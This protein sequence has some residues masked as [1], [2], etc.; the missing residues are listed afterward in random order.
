MNRSSD[1]SIG[2]PGRLEWTAFILLLLAEFLVFDQVGAAPFTRIYPRWN[3]QIQY[4]AESYTGY[5][6]LKTKGVLSAF[7]SSLATPT[8][9]GTLHDFYALVVFS[10]AGPSR[11]AALAVNMLALLVWQAACFITVRRIWGSRSLAWASCGILISL[12]APWMDIPGS[13]FD[14]RLDWMTACTMGTTLCACILARGFRNLG[15]SLVFGI[16]AALTLLTR[17]L[18]G[19]YFVLIGIGLLIWILTSKDRAV[20][21]RNL[22]FASL[23]ASLVA[24]PLMWLSR[25]EL[26]NY[27]FVGH[28]TGPESAIRNQHF[29][30]WKSITWLF[31]TLFTVQVGSLWSWGMAATLGISG[32]L[33]ACWKSVRE[34]FHDTSDAVKTAALFFIC[35][36]IVLILHAQKSFVVVSILL[37]GLVMLSIALLALFWMRLPRLARGGM[38]TLVFLGGISVFAH[39]MF[40]RK[41]PAELAT[42]TR[43]VTDLALDI[44]RRAQL[45]GLQSPRVAIDQVNDIADAQIMR[46]LVYER[47]HVWVP[48]EMTLPISIAAAPEEEIM[49]RIGKSDFVLLT[50]GGRYADYP[51]DRQTREM[52]PR[53]RAWCD[54]NMLFLE[55][56]SIYDMKLRYYQRANL[57]PSAQ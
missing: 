10:L 23:L 5:E 37:P 39:Q 52:E 36:S 21:L 48:F 51:F 13:A 19:A 28:F 25:N 26:F 24:G 45:A 15:W 49:A 29:G 38:S 11:S 35:P 3:D 16:L 18:S 17:F 50:T 2:M 54:R 14:F 57:S 6:L 44:Y 8:A 41:P 30:I 4:L 42:Y 27:Y 22:L 12:A 40:V 56:F 33:F 47:R 9:Q 32:L 20:R 55:E 1:S 34:S 31:N 7:W 53:M 43:K 46:V